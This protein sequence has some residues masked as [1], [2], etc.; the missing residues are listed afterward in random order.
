[1]PRVGLILTPGFADWEYAFIAGTAAPF[2]GIE[3]RFFTP[4]PGHFYSQG[5]LHTSV[6]AGLEQCLAWQPA[7]V[8]VVGGTLWESAQA[9]D[10]GSFLQT[11][12]AQGATVAGIC[13][14]TLA[15]ARAGL[16]DDRAHTSNSPDFLRDNAPGYKG[17]DHYRGSAKA[18]VADRVITAPGPAP[19]SFT[20]AVFEAAGLDAGLRE[21]F[22]AMLAAE[23][24]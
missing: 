13:G 9:P 21:Q 3:T 10:L 12:H 11:S 8:V 2:Y 16:L 17:T 24:A 14:G 22:Q 20:C 23:H 4:Q 1:M 6:N 7:V 19:V 18:V 5:G 15:L